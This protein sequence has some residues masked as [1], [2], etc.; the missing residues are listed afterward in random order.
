MYDHGMSF[1]AGAYLLSSL[2]LHQAPD[3]SNVLGALNALSTS[4]SPVVCVLVRL[5]EPS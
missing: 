2:T 3:G 5:P 1:N 4:S